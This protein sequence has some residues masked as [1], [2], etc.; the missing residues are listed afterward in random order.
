VYVVPLLLVATNRVAEV[1]PSFWVWAALACLIAGAAGFATGVLYARNSV[2]RTLSSAHRHVS[3]L[4]RIVVDSLDHAH[5][6][7]AILEKLPDL[8]LSLRQTESLYGKKTELLKTVENIV[9]CQTER[10]AAVAKKHEQ[11]AQRVADELTN[12]WMREPA[13]AATGIPDRPAFD[14]NLQ[15]L[16]E[17]CTQTETESGLL[18][19]RLDKLERH[20]ARYGASCAER[21]LK[22]MSSIVCRALRE[23]DIVCRFRRDTFAVLFANVDEES[24]K[25]LSMSLRNSVRAYQFRSD[26]HGPEVL[27]TASF[28]YT[29]CL[30]HD[31]AELVLNRADN[32]LSQSTRRGRNRLHSHDGAELTAC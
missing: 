31:T 18:L 26:D 1:P 13:D 8:K 27:V 29:R 7:C 25:A 6:A 19:V 11:T 10:L 32:A 30:P 23:E 2:Q 12:C 5:Q 17:F 24:G 22:I 3:R 28:G 15:K 9:E 4:Y 14:V 20:T 21:F 16:L